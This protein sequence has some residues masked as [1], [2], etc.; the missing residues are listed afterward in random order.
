MAPP[1]IEKKNTTTDLPLRPKRKT[2]LML[3]LERLI[4]I[5]KSK[6]TYGLQ[7]NVKNIVYMLLHEM[8]NP[9]CV[10]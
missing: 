1:Q 8:L 10:Y 9:Q 3:F 4:N 7:T 6:N 2:K 5:K